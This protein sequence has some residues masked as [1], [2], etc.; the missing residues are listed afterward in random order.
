MSADK[1]TNSLIALASALESHGFQTQFIDQWGWQGTPFNASDLAVMS[2]Q[3]AHDIK[4][5][6][7]TKASPEAAP[8][9]SDLATR[10]D[11]TRNS[12]L[13]S[14]NGGYMSLD[15]I[16]NTLM[17]VEWL[18]RGFIS[19]DVVQATLKPASTLG[20]RIKVAHDQLDSAIS[21][22]EGIENT[23]ERILRAADAAEKL[24]ITVNDLDQALKFAGVTK[25]AVVRSQLA[26]EE[27]ASKA[28]ASISA[29]SAHELNADAILKKI[30]S[31]YG[32]ATTIG[33]AKSFDEKAKELNKSMGIW[34]IVLIGALLLGVF[35]GQDR[36]PQLMK[37]LEGKPDW[38]VVLMY[39]TISALSLGPSVWLAWI[40]TKQIGQRFR[41]AE[42]YGYKAS[43]AKAY[44]GY[45][46]EAESLDPLF[47]AQLFAI[48]LGRLEELPL[49]TIAKDVAGSP[50]NDLL[51]S[52]QFKDQLDNLP[53][54]KGVMIGLLE[55]TMPES[56]IEKWLKGHPSR[57]DNS[58]KENNQDRD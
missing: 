43:L 35:V 57:K 40:A 3:I 9:F 37:A 12:I 41:L 28:T 5:I 17:G 31:A 48:A 42:D 52:P 30:N 11:K 55:R 18:V 44:E 34:V 15:A 6:D 19:E 46:N 45:R 16:M 50:L 47:S 23:T 2:R 53:G 32:A 4:I 49:R 36:F 27:A 7:W 29:L 20:R 51:Q 26:A 25:E 14:L 33:L 22:I 21:K 58:Q 56:A 1:L 39:M 24:D 54:F 13:P 10:V 8:R 38:G